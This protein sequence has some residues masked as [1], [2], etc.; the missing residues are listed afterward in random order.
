[1]IGFN[2]LAGTYPDEIYFKCAW[3][4]RGLSE[5]EIV[6]ALQISFY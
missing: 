1:M 5:L 3:T 2:K 4:R 6:K